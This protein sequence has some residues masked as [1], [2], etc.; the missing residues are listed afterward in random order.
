MVNKKSIG[1]T[2]IKSLILAFSVILLTLL[3]SATPSFL[4]LNHSNNDSGIVYADTKENGGHSSSKKKKDDEIDPDDYN[5]NAHKDKDKDKDKDDDSSPLDKLVSNTMFMDALE[6]LAKNATEQ[7]SDSDKPTNSSNSKKSE[8]DADLAGDGVNAGSMWAFMG[9]QNDDIWT[10]RTSNSFSTTYASLN[11]VHKNA[12][13]KRNDKIT[14]HYAAAGNLAYALF[15]TGIDRSGTMNNGGIG[16]IGAGLSVF[17]SAVVSILMQLCFHLAGIVQKVLAFVIKL[18]S[19]FNVFDWA[20]HGTGSNNELF[21]PLINFVHSLYQ[22]TSKI[23]F[24]ACTTI[25]AI[26]LAL[27]ILGARSMGTSYV[28]GIGNSV[29]TMFKRMFVMIVLPFLCLISFNGMMKQLEDMYDNNTN[30][31]SNYAVYSNFIDYQSWVMNSRV[32]IPEGVAL[33]SEYSSRFTPVLNHESILSINAN[34]AGIKQASNVMNDNWT[35]NLASQNTKQKPETDQRALSMIKQWGSS[36][37]FTAADYASHVQ[38]YIKMV[39]S[40]DKKYKGNGKKLRTDLTNNIYTLNGL[41]SAGGK[42]KFSTSATAYSDKRLSPDRSGGFSTLG[43]YAYLLT[44]CS[45][46]TI[47]TTNTSLLGNLVSMPA[48]QSV[49]LVGGPLT[50]ASNGFIALALMLCSTILAVGV[51]YFTFIGLME[52]ATSSLAGLGYSALGALGGGVK[53]LS[54]FIGM[55]ISL[56]GTAILYQLACKLLIAVSRSFD[57]FFTSGTISSAVPLLGFTH[58]GS[59][60]V[61]GA[62]LSNSA[63]IIINF[64]EGLLLIYFAVLFLKMRGPIL[65]ATSGAVED[66]ANRILRSESNRMYSNSSVH[67]NIGGSS[68]SSGNRTINSSHNGKFAGLMGRND[69]NTASGPSVFNA[70]A[71]NDI[72]E[73]TD[74]NLEG[75]GSSDNNVDMDKSIDP[76][77]DAIERQQDQKGDPLPT[78]ASGDVGD[79]DSETKDL[80]DRSTETAENT[81]NNVDNP[82]NME[83]KVSAAGDDVMVNNDA[84]AAMGDDL[85]NAQL[86]QLSN[87]ADAFNEQ[88]SVQQEGDA[89]N[90]MNADN[91]STADVNNNATNKVDNKDNANVNNDVQNTLDAKTQGSLSNPVSSPKSLD[92]LLSLKQ[93]MADVNKK[94]KAVKQAA[95]AYQAVPSASLKTKL[96]DAKSS[97]HQAQVGAMASYNKQPASVMNKSMVRPDSKASVGEVNN[98]IV[99]VYKSR[100][101]L[102]A[103]TLKIGNNP[104]QL[105]PQL[106]SYKSA[107]KS[108]ES[109]GVKGGIVN[110]KADP[111]FLNKAYET[112]RSNQQAVATGKLDVSG[113]IN[114]INKQ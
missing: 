39:E 46:S 49:V 92:S 86:D 2:L 21:G 59:M 76:V 19:Y 57:S 68:N 16:G 62:A 15:S 75:T 9:P 10:G 70:G 87:E 52:G 22:A 66:F 84:D 79:V 114:G 111:R 38:S 55:V 3:S 106:N 74:T 109:L 44:T 81:Q 1:S 18:F 104:E 102:K 67:N 96:N 48:H 30:S 90:S 42:G 4:S 45:N 80:S 8:K 54:A 11:D 58:N 27:A 112:V 91:S 93:S 41:T 85:Q 94:G 28:G 7:A 105:K 95:S 77:S 88:N 53:L 17:L 35:S 97:Y 56:F 33:Q 78:S 65:A 113:Y 108:A 26:S 103:Q 63:Y 32:A 37:S 5:A 13:G 98:A 82:E 31:I 73:S 72:D 60:Q 107:I 83:Q 34:G 40:G 101:A 36:N 64:L 69:K 29:M 20:L 6:D 23:G 14:G 110:A 71:N 24:V 51:V 61:A 50:A 89:D 25:F 12:S 100:E 47:D 99:G 43:M